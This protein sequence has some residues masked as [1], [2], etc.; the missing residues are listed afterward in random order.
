MFQYV[1]ELLVGLPYL[2]TL[3]LRI[4]LEPTHV[5]TTLLKVDVD[6]CKLELANMSTPKERLDLAL[7]N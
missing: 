1:K 6:F 2:P 3:P 5:S 7:A 4:G